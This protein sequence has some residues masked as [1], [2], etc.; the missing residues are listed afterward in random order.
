MHEFSTKIHRQ[1]GRTPRRACCRRQNIQSGSAHTS[2]EPFSRA[3]LGQRALRRLHYAGLGA[4]SRLSCAGPG[5]RR[6]RGG[7]TGIAAPWLGQMSGFGVRWCSGQHLINEIEQ[8]GQTT[9]KRAARDAQQ[10][11]WQ[12]VLCSTCVRGRRLA[13]QRAERRGSFKNQSSKNTGTHAWCKG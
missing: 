6:L 1:V 7:G 12:A 9:H 4:G 10:C 8:E 2:L 11:V 5:R 13:E 3:L